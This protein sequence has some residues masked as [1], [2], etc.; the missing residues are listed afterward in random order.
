MTFLAFKGIKIIHDV[1]F[2][3]ITKHKQLSDLHKNR[4]KLVWIRKTN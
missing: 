4:I 3:G 1:C 2:M